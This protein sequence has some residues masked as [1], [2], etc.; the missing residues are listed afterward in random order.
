MGSRHRSA[1]RAV[2]LHGAGGGGWQW[3]AWRRVFR[4]GGWSVSAPDLQPAS[5]GLG[6]T[7]LADYRAQV[8]GLSSDGGV[9]LVGASLGGWLALAASAALRPMA[10]VLI[11][12]VPPA[13]V[14]GRPAGD[15]EYPDVVRWHSAP[16]FRATQRALPDGDF[17]AQLLAHRNWRD[18][19][20]HVLAELH[21]GA[22]VASHSAPT[23]V[24]AAERDTEVPPETG[25]ALAAGIGADFVLV[26]G[27][28]H[29][30]PLLGDSATGVARQ[31]RDWL[32]LVLARSG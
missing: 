19:S 12:P 25:R 22:P 3:A 13:G 15:A 9:V 6:A 30:G 29:L 20:G 14:P 21:A 31:A 2:F 4:A 23:L 8:E 1:P 7:R 24:L 5:G 32:A 28:S 18:E 16:D 27:A 26:R 11:N 17:G 10:R